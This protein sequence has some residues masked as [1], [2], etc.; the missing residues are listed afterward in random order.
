MSFLIDASAAIHLLRDRTGLLKGHYDSIVG[1]N[2]VYLGQ[3]TMFEVLK[4][5]SDATEW[6]RL[7]A[8]LASQR[9]LP[10]EDGDWPAAARIVADLRW[11]GI[12]L[13]NTIDALVAAT[14]LRSDLTILHDDRDF[15]L[16]AKARPVK[17]H[18]FSPRNITTP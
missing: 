2:P 4:G 15:E 6:T 11:N 14:A 17:L 12:T 16:I 7:E 9:S 1:A 18:R 13:K 10:F 3:L 5:A 8:M